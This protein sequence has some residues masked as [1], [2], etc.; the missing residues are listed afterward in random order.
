MTPCTLPNPKGPITGPRTPPASP[1]VGGPY[2]SPLK[3]WI[4]MI[5]TEG[6]KWP[7]DTLTYKNNP[8]R[9]V[10]IDGAPWFSLEDITLT[11][12]YRPS[13]AAYVDRRAFP[14]F[15]KRECQE[16]TED[17]M[18]DATIISPVG[19]WYF[20]NLTDARKGEKLAAWAKREAIRLC[21]DAAPDDRHVFLTLDPHGDLPPCPT[22]YSGRISEW[23]DLK[24]AAAYHRAQHGRPPLGSDRRELMQSLLQQAEKER[25]ESLKGSS[26]SPNENEA[27]CS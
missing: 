16:D 4:I 26:L 17:G 2:H 12:G 6:P 18:I 9:I 27:V 8:I 15:A 11:L 10:M 7:T 21:P 22:K 20:T 3:F 13:V 1:D 19:V 25:L 24:D 5:T 23:L 14:A